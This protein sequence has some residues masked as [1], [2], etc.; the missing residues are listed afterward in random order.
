MQVKKM[1]T[2]MLAYQWASL[3]IGSA[4][5]IAGHGNIPLLIGTVISGVLIIYDMYKPVENK[6]ENI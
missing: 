6:N 5:I 1:N 4:V 3:I 2:L